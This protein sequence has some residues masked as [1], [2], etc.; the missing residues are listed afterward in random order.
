MIIIQYY[1]AKVAKAAAA[2]QLKVPSKVRKGL[3]IRGDT[4]MDGKVKKVWC[5][6]CKEGFNY[7]NWSAHCSKHHPLQS[8]DVDELGKVDDEDNDGER[9]AT[10]KKAKTAAP[11]HRQKATSG[12]NGA[13]KAKKARVAPKG[14][15][16][17]GSSCRA[18]DSCAVFNWS[19]LS[20]YFSYVPSIIFSFFNRPL[21]LN[22][23]FKQILIQYYCYNNSLVSLL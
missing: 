11:G 3:D 9:K 19:S 16:S 13:Q 7:S 2:A 1:P 22:L 23:L 15:F 20:M 21:F 5:L 10:Q 17:Q 14:K 6:K 18:M 12:D 8:S 4:Y